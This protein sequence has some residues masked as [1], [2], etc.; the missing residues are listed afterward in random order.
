MPRAIVI[1]L[2]LCQQLFE[3][4]LILVFYFLFN[5]PF[6]NAG[7]LILVIAAGAARL[8]LSHGFL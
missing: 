7:H 2:S 8:V 5:V 4:D 3:I 6:E 1:L